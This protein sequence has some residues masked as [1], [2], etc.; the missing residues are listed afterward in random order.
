[1]AQPSQLLKPSSGVDVSHGFVKDGQ[2][3]EEHTFECA[4][5]VGSLRPWVAF[6]LGLSCMSFTVENLWGELLFSPNLV[7]TQSL[8]GLGQDFCPESFD[9]ST[10]LL[11]HHNVHRKQ[12]F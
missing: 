11:E 1:M 8:Q 12:T 10:E 4:L 7:P 3:S 6:S 5:V 2:F 9:V